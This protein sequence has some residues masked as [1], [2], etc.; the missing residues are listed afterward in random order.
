LYTWPELVAFRAPQLE[1]GGVLCLEL[2][3]FE[4]VPLLDLAPETDFTLN[5]SIGVRYFLR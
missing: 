1:Y 4:I 2:V 3:R 5:G